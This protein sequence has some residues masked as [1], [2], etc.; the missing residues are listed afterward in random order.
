[1]LK[2]NGTN[3]TGAVQ[4]PFNLV[5]GPNCVA[6]GPNLVCTFQIDAPVG[7]DIF[8]ANTYSQ[9]N[10]VSA[11]GSG[12]IAL[13]IQANA[14]NNANLS[15]TGP[16][17]SVQLFCDQCVGTYPQ[18]TLYNATGGGPLLSSVARA[19]A[20]ARRTI[21]SGS[22][23]S[24][25]L[26]VIAF[27]ANANEIINPTT[28]DIP[29]T[30]TLS[31]NGMPPGVVSLGV[32]YQFPNPN[33]T[34]STTADGGTIAVTSP[35]DVITLSLTNTTFGT[36]F[37]SVGLSYTPQGGS[38]QTPSPGTANQAITYNV[39]AP[40]PVVP[41]P[42]WAI[43]QSPSGA[44]FAINANGSFTITAT[45][46][47]TAATTGGTITVADTLPAGFTYQSATG[48]GWTCGYA[49]P[50]VTCTSTAAVAIS[51]SAPPITITALATTAVGSPFSNSFTVT[52]GG[53]PTYGS[54][55][56][57]VVNTPTFGISFSGPL[58][59]GQSGTISGILGNTGLAP[60]SGPVTLA[61]TLPAGFAI[62]SASGTGWTGC[63]TVSQV[64]TCTYNA[65]IP[66]AGSANTLNIVGVP[67][68]SGSI[69]ISAQAS[70][71]FAA[72]STTMQNLTVG[73]GSL[74]QIV[75]SQTTPFYMNNF[76]VGQASGSFTNYV[77]NPSQLAF[78][79]VTFTDSLPSG[80]T[81]TGTGTGWI[82]SGS[83]TITCTAASIAAGAVSV[84]PVVISIT[85]ASTAGNNLT[86]SSSVSATALP[87]PPPSGSSTVTVY[88]TLSATPQA[89]Y[90][91][92]SPT[93]LQLT[94]GAVG[95]IMVSEPYFTGTFTAGI[96]GSAACHSAVTLGAA[97]N[98]S[99]GA[100][101][102]YLLAV[103]GAATTGSN[104][105]SISITD[106][107]GFSPSVVP[108]TVTAVGLTGQ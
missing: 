28:F 12:S 70:G 46:S 72:T 50:V 51:S 33:P 58:T 47:G 65:S 31:L 32:T 86:N 90:V 14:V 64:V 62:S 80:M 38:L 60:T 17:A 69:G 20:A 18:P 56:T 19:P 25:R 39:N 23:T 63:T 45:N 108:F 106:A 68:T 53:A 85:G 100:G 95:Q 59:Q 16:V 82:C 55:D 102:S 101:S 10:A 8:V 49:S 87:S 22:I 76:A 15:L 81:G 40:A 44:P 57:L 5:L 6:S 97:G 99:G 77:N 66:A 83:T 7:P 52:G 75:S 37:P 1:L 29:L 43:A 26:Y 67:T 79:N 13:T 93:R 21:A 3:V 11:L 104:A 35:G 2:S 96:V 78:S 4:G 34:A 84:N 94:V 61:V 27:D 71:G 74:L 24:S 98:L 91:A 73:S 92:T 36:G 42:A 54:T 89:P 48:S 88:G 107:N 105:C 9:L 41:A 103:T 30:L